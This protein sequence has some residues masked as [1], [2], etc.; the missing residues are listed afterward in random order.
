MCNL[1][2]N[3][4][5]N[6]VLYKRI[7]ATSRDSL[8]SSYFTEIEIL[9]KKNTLHS[10]LNGSLNIDT[11]FRISHCLKIKSEDDFLKYA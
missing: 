6:C 5:L 4:I 11:P 9:L 1:K 8:Y 10:L 2:D 3:I 7:R